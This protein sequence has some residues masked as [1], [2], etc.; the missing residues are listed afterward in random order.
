MLFGTQI[1][2]LELPLHLKAT[3]PYLNYNFEPIPFISSDPIMKF[4]L[5][6]AKSAPDLSSLSLYR[7]DTMDLPAL[8]PIEVSSDTE[9]DSIVDDLSFASEHAQENLKTVAPPRKPLQWEFYGL[10]LWLELEEF[11]ND[12]THAVQD[13][14]DK[15]GV[16]RIPV[17][18][19]TAI[20]GMT[21]LTQQEACA[22][23]QT[24]RN[25]IPQWPRFSKPTGVV[26]DIAVCGRPGQVCSIAWAELTLAT[27]PDHEAALDTLYEIFFGDDFKGRDGP[28]K[29]HNSFAYDNPEDSV[30]NLV[31]AVIYC[32]EHPTLLGKERRV[33]AMSLWNTHGKMGDWK[34]LDRINFF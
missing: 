17:S 5:N 34:C 20:Y 14:T 4:N 32:A 16:E 6:A 13:A 9:T 21:H 15:Y 2:H 25:Q 33:K 12:L 28:W 26:Q 7:D 24:V 22:K 18:H 11:E 27:N 10:T 31:D 1:S 19:T 29:P 8:S 30:L 3:T 23:L